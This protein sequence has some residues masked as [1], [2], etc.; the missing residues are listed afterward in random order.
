[1]VRRTVVVALCVLASAAGRAEAADW[2]SLRTPHFLLI[3]DANAGEI[4]D[5][6][7]RFEQ[8]REVV[9][10]VFPQF[11][12]TAASPPVVIFVFKNQKSFEPFVPLFDGKRVRLGGYYLGGRDINY[13]AL[14]ADSRGP[15]FQAVYHEFAHLLMDRIDP[16]LPPWFDEGYAEYFST[17][18]LVGRDKANFGKLIAG[19]VALLRARQ[20][21]LAELFA[22]AHDSTTYNEGNRRSLFYAESWALI[23]YAMIGNRERFAPLMRFASLAR[24]GD[25]VPTAFAKAFGIPTTTLDDELRQYVQGANV[26][27]YSTAAIDQRV[28]NQVLGDV[29]RLAEPEAQAW[30]G[31]LLSHAGR[32]DEATTRLEAAL[33]MAPDLAL[34]HASL[35]ALLI[36]QDK[37][38]L[39]MPHLQRA[40]AL[41]SPNEF[42]HFYYGAALVEQAAAKPSADNT[43]LQNGIA[44]LARAVE[45]RPGFTEAQNTLGYAYLLRGET[46]KARDVLVRALAEDPSDD[47][48]ALLLARVQLRRGQ[49]DDVRRLLGPV[50]ARATEPSVTDQARELLAQSAVVQRQQQLR[51]EAGLTSTPAGAATTP[52]SVQTALRVYKP[53]FR[54][55][56]AGE[57]RTYGVFVGVECMPGQVVLQ[58]RVPGSTL[59]VRAA[60]FADVVFTSYRQVPVPPVV[61]GPRTPP[62][63]VYVTW[64]GDNGSDGTPGEPGTAVAVELLPEGFIPEP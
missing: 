9:T 10:S 11:K 34:A 50:V 60:R 20:M 64:K 30:L 43:D 44:A 37:R 36:R 53:D 29:S 45:L 5:V 26:F 2:T 59:R 56:Q 12:D 6:A 4:R 23:H 41:N 63:E 51:R 24:G 61:C 62:D 18:E 46:E 17:F 55:R 39:A 14:A 54:E 22:V 15:D 13:I 16:D 7:L 32:T 28:S 48:G 19:H 27:L 38:D 58:M 57:T 42:V 25:A 47:R 33:T 21:P 35:A 31:D 49:V 8:F 52:D 3:G 40:A 1:V